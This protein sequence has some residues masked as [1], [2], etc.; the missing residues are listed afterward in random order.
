MSHNPILTLEVMACCS[1]WYL[2]GDEQ[3]T[4]Y[5]QCRVPNRMVDFSRTMIITKDEVQDHS[6]KAKAP[7]WKVTVVPKFQTQVTQAHIE[8]AHYLTLATVP[9]CTHFTATDVEQNDDLLRRI[10]RAI[11]DYLGEG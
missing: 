3:G 8:T 4:L 9:Y 5:L 2:L 6:K 7:A 10:A 1:E 11:Y